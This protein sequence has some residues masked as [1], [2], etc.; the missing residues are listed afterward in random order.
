MHWMHAFIY[1]HFIHF[2]MH[3]FVRSFIQSVND[4]NKPSGTS[5][6]REIH[7]SQPLRQ[8][9]HPQ[10]TVLVV[11]LPFSRFAH[12]LPGP[13]S[14]GGSST[15][16][17]SLWVFVTPIWRPFIKAIQRPGMANRSLADS[18]KPC[19]LP[20]EISQIGNEMATPRTKP[21]STTNPDSTTKV[22][23]P[24]RRIQQP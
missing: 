17:F 9:L 3:M 14:P 6:S 19:L 20:L 10:L 18:E 1:I 2:Y 12:S 15:V 11:S 5:K 21:D 4:P 7:H 16:S 22:Q 23:Q 24:K 8:P 13:G